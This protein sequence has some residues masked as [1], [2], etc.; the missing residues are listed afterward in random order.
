MHKADKSWTTKEISL[1]KRLNSPQK[2]QTFLNSLKFNFEK[3][4]DTCCSPRFVIKNKTA[5]CMEGAM[6]AAAVLEFNGDKPLVLDLRSVA[7]DFDHVVAV[8]K[9]FGCY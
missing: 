3:K 8:F 9:K 2:I 4:G 6:F 1:F 7:H 5:H